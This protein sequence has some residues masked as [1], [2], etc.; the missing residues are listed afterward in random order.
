MR[1]VAAND[2]AREAYM[3]AVSRHAVQLADAERKRA[4][5]KAAAHAMTETAVELLRRTVETAM[6]LGATVL[7]PGCLT[8]TEKNDACMHMK[9]SCGAEFCYCCGRFSARSG[10]RIAA[11]TACPPTRLQQYEARGLRDCP[12]NPGGNEPGCDAISCYLEKTPGFQRL[13]RMRQASGS[14]ESYGDAARNEFHRQRIAAYLCMVKADADPATWSEFESTNP[15]LLQNTPTKGRCISWDELAA[16]RLPLFG[17]TP[18]DQVV[19]PPPLLELINVAK[20]APQALEVAVPLAEQALWLNP[21]SR[22]IEVEFAHP[23]H[24][25]IRFAEY[26][27]AEYGGNVMVVDAIAAGSQ[28][29]LV[30]QL[31][32]GML[33]HSVNGQRFHHDA[34]SEFVAMTMTRPGE[35]LSHPSPHLFLCCGCGWILPRPQSVQCLH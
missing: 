14:L 28:A 33:L 20:V 32:T 19:L 24:I 7:C 16:T 34:F 4:A 17:N 12:R 13:P 9:C 35:T 11:G 8:A 5:A 26:Q 29:A 25:G 21:G 15:D 23:S 18:A 22:L 10:Q 3:S 27:V 31:Q 6:A 1:T 30:I 2:S